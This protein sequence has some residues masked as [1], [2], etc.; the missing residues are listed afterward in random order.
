MPVSDGRPEAS[1]AAV[2]VSS[3]G[4]SIAVRHSL[5]RALADRVPSRPAGERAWPRPPLRA[6]GAASCCVCMAV[7]MHGC[8]AVSKT[9]AVCRIYA[10]PE[11]TCAYGV[12]QPQHKHR[13][14]GHDRVHSRQTLTSSVVPCRRAWAGP[15][16]AHAA[17]A[18]RAAGGAALQPQHTRQHAGGQSSG[19]C[20]HSRRGCHG[21]IHPAC[22]HVPPPGVLS[23]L[24]IQVQIPAM[25]IW[26]A[27]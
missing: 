17:E 21:C 16:R 27:L 24:R 26:T 2:E 4:Q 5:E 10:E 25:S 3:A 22:S 19:A 6:L 13:A 8:Y 20:Q 1:P 7:C 18:Q 12:L 11:C 23:T 14:S 15:H 9:K